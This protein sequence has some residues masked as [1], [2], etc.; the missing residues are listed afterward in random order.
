M[1]ET[2][3]AAVDSGYKVALV[4]KSG[5]VRYSLP[6]T[7][8]SWVTVE[9]DRI[10]ELDASN[11]VVAFVNNL[12]SQ[13]V[14]WVTSSNINTELGVDA[15]KISYTTELKLSPNVQAKPTLTVDYYLFAKDG[16]YTDQGETRQAKKGA[17]KLNMS[18]VKW[19]FASQ[20]N[21]L[22]IG[23]STHT[24]SGGTPSKTSASE[25]RV[26]AVKV[27][28]ASKAGVDGASRSVTAQNDGNTMEWVFPAFTNRLDYD[29]VFSSA[30]GGTSSD[31]GMTTMLLVV[32]VAVWYLV[33]NK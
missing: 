2:E 25:H 18:L 16:S 31:S 8:S 19:P 12:A 14:K 26:G 7:S 10:R 21:Q 23:F 6:G 9:L 29:P 32:A 11:K 13:E 17:M 3:I 5:K 22:A 15:Y 20:Q 30:S 27:E 33:L 24:N 1:S 4:G 28:S